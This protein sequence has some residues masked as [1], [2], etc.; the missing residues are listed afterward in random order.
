MN[1]GQ[2]I[3]STEPVKNAMDYGCEIKDLHSDDP[4][5]LIAYGPCCKVCDRHGEIAYIIGKAV[6]YLVSWF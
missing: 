2:L 4:M 1:N 3:K 5:L 6:D